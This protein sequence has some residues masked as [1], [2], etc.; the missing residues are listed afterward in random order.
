[1]SVDSPR[2]VA[3]QAAAALA[4]ELDLFAEHDMVS[5][6]RSLGAVLAGLPSRP[7]EVT[8]AL[9]RYASS[10]G[11]VPVSALGRWLG[12]QAPPPVPLD[13]KDRR[14]AD[15]AWND[16]PAFYARRVFYIALARL[17]EEL[18]DAADVNPVAREKAR[19]AMELLIN[20]SSPTNF[21]ST[22]PAALKHAFDTGGM[23]L[24]KGLRNWVD[25]LVNNGG[26]PRQVDRSPF[27]VGE[28]LAATPSKVVYR[29]DLM[30]LLQYEPQTEKVHANPLLMS[31]PWINK[32]YVMD[33]APNRSFIEWAVQHGRTVFVLSYRNPTPEM[34]GVTMDD[35]LV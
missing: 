15:P 17:S 2:D 16:N 18:V 26:R 1:M 27:R 22:N 21:L 9:T 4:P 19:V 35:Y 28:N 7:A 14:I 25:D 20:A 11:Q 33:L 8:R 10:V 13:P 6:G 31:P 3:D 30:E 24:L 32:Y 23:S 12:S 5:F 29:N 34:S